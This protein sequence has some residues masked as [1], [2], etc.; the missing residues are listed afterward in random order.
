MLEF[1]VE[2]LGEFLLQALGYKKAKVLHGGLAAWTS[3]GKPITTVAPTPTEEA[4]PEA[5]ISE[6]V[7]EQTTEAPSDQ[8]VPEEVT[9]ETAPKETGEVLET[10][11]NKDQEVATAAPAKSPLPKKRP[12][13]PA[14]PA[15]APAETAEAPSSEPVVEEAPAVQADDAVAE[16]LRKER[17]VEGHQQDEAV[18]HDHHRQR[19]PPAERGALSLQFQVLGVGRNLSNQIV[20][21]GVSSLGSR[22]AFGRP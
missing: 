17:L 3:M 1:I 14:E 18:V 21:H 2:I 12:E 13:K 20:I 4:K 10:E 15:P 8:P 7:Q 9:E 19:Q 5:D 22:L 11:E 16:A 6:Q